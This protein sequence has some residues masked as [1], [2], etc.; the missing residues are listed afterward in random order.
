[1]FDDYQ[2]AGYGEISVGFGRKPAI[3]VVDFQK[4]HTSQEFPFGGKPL[5]MRALENTRKLL[6]VARPLNIPVAICFTA[7]QSEKDMPY[8]KIRPVRENYLPGNKAIEL[9]EEL[10]DPTYDLI[11]RKTGPSMFYETK[12]E[13]FLIKAGVDT[14]IVTGVNTSGCI[15]ATVIDSFQRGY[16]TIVPEPCVGDVEEG[17]HRYNLRDVGRRYADV[18]EL[19]DVLNYLRQL[20]KTDTID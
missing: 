3:L 14:V 20:P 5:A 7:Y 12:I 4:S 13:P 11:I 18:V 6:A 9:E 2:S 19:E 17:P 10:A 16:R 15:R 1:M 8:W